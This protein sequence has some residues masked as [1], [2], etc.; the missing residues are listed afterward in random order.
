MSE[1]FCRMSG[2]QT[3]FCPLTTC[4][5]HLKTSVH[6]QSRWRSEGLSPRWL[7]M[8][9]L[10]TPSML[11]QH[12]SREDH[13]I[14]AGPPPLECVPRPL[15]Q[16]PLP[17]SSSQLPGQQ[18]PGKPHLSQLPLCVCLKGRHPALSRKLRC[19]TRDP[20]SSHDFSRTWE[21][22]RAELLTQRLQ[23]KRSGQA[24]HTRPSFG[25]SVTPSV[26]QP[27]GRQPAS[28]PCRSPSPGIRSR[29]SCRRCHPTSSSSVVP[30]A[31]NLS[32]HQQT[33]GPV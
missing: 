10:H 15:T 25:H 8:A 33:R 22:R 16:D 28:P 3:R 7:L 31:L 29:P 14:L 20:A 9:S 26:L 17:R 6:F 4:V 32:Q 12:V 1:Q 19:C 13:L 30:S 5:Q 23:Q 21:G 18:R 24:Q 27:R 2:T 11:V